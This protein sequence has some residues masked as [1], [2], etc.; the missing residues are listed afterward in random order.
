MFD[1]WYLQGEGEGEI[2]TLTL[3][4]KAAK[5]MNITPLLLRIV[6]NL[7]NVSIGDALGIHNYDLRI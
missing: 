6:E 7:V 2:Q 1:D 5:P 4:L 3:N